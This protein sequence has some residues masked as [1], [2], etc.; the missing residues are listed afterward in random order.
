M[1]VSCCERKADT[2]GKGGLTYL[3]LPEVHKQVE[4]KKED[5]EG[6]GKNGKEAGEGERKEG[7]REER[8]G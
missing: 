7:E 2:W 8:G 6:E 4:K 5:K 1:G 3:A